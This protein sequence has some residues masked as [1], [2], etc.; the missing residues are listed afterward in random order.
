MCISH[1]FEVSHSDDGVLKMF[2]WGAESNVL[3][4]VRVHP[5]LPESRT[6]FRRVE[7]FGH[8]QLIK[9]IVNHV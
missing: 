3:L 6:R 8:A 7:K 4:R 1:Q 9:D 2:F 5:D